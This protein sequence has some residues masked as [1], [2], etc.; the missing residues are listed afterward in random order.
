MSPIITRALDIH[1]SGITVIYN[2]A[3]L[4][5]TA[6]F[7]TET[8]TEDDRRVWLTAHGDRFPVLVATVGDRVAGWASVTEYSPRPAYQFT[9]EDSVY[10]HPDFQGQGIGKL[11]LMSLLDEAR[12]AG[13]H[14][15]IGRVVD[16]NFASIHLHRQAGFEE[17]GRLREVG[18]KFGQWL[19][20]LFV[21]VML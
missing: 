8:K 3:I 4:N 9:G 10:V 12:V 1:V 14:S 15:L 13:F 11:L 7:D 20:V 2:H 6:T 21:Q 16:G 5:T 17:V 19:D 18:Q